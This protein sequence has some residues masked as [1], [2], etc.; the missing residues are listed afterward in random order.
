[1]LRKQCAI[2]KEVLDFDRFGLDSHADDQKNSRCLECMRE[3]VRQYRQE[4]P[5]RVKESNRRRAAAKR[6]G[7]PKKVPVCPCGSKLPS[8]KRRYCDPCMA[9]RSTRSKKDSHLRRN[10]GVTLEW[11]EKTLLDQK[12][13]CA[14]CCDPLD[15]S[16]NTH[17]DHDHTTGAVRGLLCNGCNIGLGYFQDSPAR[18][19]AAIEYL[20]N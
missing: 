3:R 15:Y 6:A 4:N 8:P 14:I 20:S 12:A 1:M 7:I 16:T 10:R 18:M 2:C 11:Y 17:V 19:A 13:L 9:E 5:D